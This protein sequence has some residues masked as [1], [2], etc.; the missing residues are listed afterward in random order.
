[1]LV[2]ESGRGDSRVSTWQ[3]I[4]FAYNSLNFKLFGIAILQQTINCQHDGKP[5]SFLCSEQL[6]IIKL[7]PLM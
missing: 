6:L 4:V 3:S 7:N 2:G 1:M 5:F